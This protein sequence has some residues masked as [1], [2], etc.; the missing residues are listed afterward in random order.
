MS[1]QRPHPAPLAA[2][3]DR[4]P[5][6]YPCGLNVTT[7]ATRRRTCRSSCRKR[8]PIPAQLRDA[9]NISHAIDDDGAPAG[10]S[11]ALGETRHR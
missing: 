10:V 4:S 5:R 3:S 1:Q 2:S 7:I 9:D 11:I 6:L 8:A